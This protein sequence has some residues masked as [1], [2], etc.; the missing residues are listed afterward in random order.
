MNIKWFGGSECLVS[1]TTAHPANNMCSS[2]GS[3]DP[4]PLLRYCWLVHRVQQKIGHLS[5]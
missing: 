4:Q 3:V 1:K 2:V 5:R